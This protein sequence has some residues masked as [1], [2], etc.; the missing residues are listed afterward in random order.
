MSYDTTAPIPGWPPAEPAPPRPKRWRVRPRWAFAA[1]GV[2]VVA[3]IAG[4]LVWQPWNPPPNS[5]TA[6]HVVSLT[7]TSADVSW[8]VPKGGAKPDHYIIFRDDKQAGEVPASQTSW[9]DS[10][11]APGSSHKYTVEAAAGGQQ[12]GQS[13]K[14]AVTT[15]TPPPVKLAVSS[16]TYTSEVLTWS[17]SSLGPGP[18]TTRSTTGPP[19]SAPWPARPTPTRS[20]D[21]RR[22]VATS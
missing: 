8:T 7:A 15:I 19:C 12:S 9:T 1:G 5:P 4:L 11:L 22:A 6:I 21:W 20:P 14:V 17:A 3:L 10:G 13:V 2:A 16:V 18:T